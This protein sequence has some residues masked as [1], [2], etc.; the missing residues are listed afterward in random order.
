ML[1]LKVLITITYKYWKMYNFDEYN[2]II[3]LQVIIDNVFSFN[4]YAYWYYKLT[5]TLYLLFNG[6]YITPLYTLTVAHRS[7]T[8]VWLHSSCTI[9]Q[10]VLSVYS[11]NSTRFY[12]VQ[13]VKILI[14][15]IAFIHTYAQIFVSSFHSHFD[16]FSKENKV[17]IYFLLTFHF[18]EL[19]R[20]K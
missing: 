19:V 8:E 2:F 7:F 5:F 10:I 16:P 4:K 17:N 15:I 9:I 1:I 20:R 6:N 11:W 12:N 3:C 14:Y 18:A 13:Y